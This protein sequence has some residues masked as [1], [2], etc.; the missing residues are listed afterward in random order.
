MNISLNWLSD[1]IELSESPEEISEILTMAG[2]EVASISAGV[3]YEGVIVGEVIKCDKHPNADKLSICE[4]NIG[5]AENL[6]I[7]CGAPN[8]KAGQKVPVALV[9]TELPGNLKIK[10]AKIRGEMSNG[11]ICSEKELNISDSSDG[12]MVLDKSA[13]VG[14]AISEVLKPDDTVLE[15]DLTPN[16]PD[17]L[18]HIGVARDISAI[19]N[20][21]VT[22]PEFT[23]E[24]SSEDSTASFKIKILDSEGCPRF[25]ARIIKGVKLKESPDWMKKRLESVGIRAINNVV[26]ASN[27]VLMESGHPI[28][29]FDMDRLSGNRIEVRSSDKGEKVTTLDGVERELP[30]GTVLVCDADK[31][32][33]IGGIM[34]LDNSE[35][36]ESTVNLLIECAQFDAGRIRSSSKSLGLYTEA[37]KR[38]E[39]GCDP[40][41]IEYSLDRITSLILDTAGGAALKGIIDEYPGEIQRRTLTLRLSRLNTIVG[42]E[43]PKKKVLEILS[44]LEYEIISKEKD[45]LSLSVPSFRP[46]VTGEID[47]IE[48]IARIY[49]YDNIP[50]AEVARIRLE[51]PSNNNEVLNLRIKNILVGLGAT[52]IYTNSLMPY[53]MWK[54]SGQDNKPVR[55][56]N[57]VSREMECLRSSLMPRMLETVQYNLNRQ[58][59]G[60]K[61]FEDGVVAKLDQ[62][63]ETGVSE[64]QMI[65]VILAGNQSPP[66]WMAEERETDFYTLKN[67]AESFLISCGFRTITQ[68]PAPKRY[69]ES[70]FAIFGDGV[71]IGVMGEISGNLIK[72]FDLD[73]KV[74]YFEADVN[75]LYVQLE[76]EVSFSEP[77]KYPTIERDISFIVDQKI[78][79][80]QLTE[81][82]RDNGGELL[83]DLNISSVYRGEPLASDERSITYHLRFSSTKSTLV[84]YEI[85]T[86][87][88]K[89]VTEANK[90][91]GARIRE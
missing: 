78:K 22:K 84:E 41:D 38:F 1:F 28:H 44:K 56:K 14:K 40:G 26:D 5:N 45:E 39:R 9:G 89:I 51:S 21:K 15:L 90:K 49:G 63:S 18:S 70:A 10:K 50:P 29:I 62:S 81:I 31:P 54:L 83:S 8:V 46:D 17:A 47:V 33:G 30:E 23:L 35:V 3:S 72:K 82:V 24:E 76:K 20:K 32:V 37:S 42:I 43:I 12:I 65:G 66:N 88:M 73:E 59:S 2:L 48:E 87:C 19:L 86:I 71:E 79:S 80:E 77:S 67:N 55:V 53:E 64:T 25:A 52:E 34:G 68:T 6:S 61:F 75:P 58:Q 36:S 60:V 11:M 27:Y 13:E 4:V 69:F 74:Y 57:P 91:S 7:V 85:D 16:R